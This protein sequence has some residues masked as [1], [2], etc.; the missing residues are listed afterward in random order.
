MTSRDLEQRYAGAHF[1]E[2]P[3]PAQKLAQVVRML[4]LEA[5]GDRE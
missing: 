1:L 5:C 2:K 3:Y 4:V